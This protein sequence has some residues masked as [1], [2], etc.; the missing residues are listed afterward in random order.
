ME[1]QTSNLSGGFVSSQEWTRLV[2]LCS[3]MTG[4]KDS[5]EDLAQETVLE[6]WLHKHTLRNAGKRDQW[7]SGIARNVC[8]RW[9]RTRG[10]ELA[11]LAI[12]EGYAEQDTSPLE[13]IRSSNGISP[14]RNAYSPRQTL[15]R[16]VTTCR[17]RRTTRHEHECG[18]NA[19]T[20]R[21]TR[22]TQSTHERDEPRNFSL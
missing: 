22:T 2:H 4:N 10:R 1:Q 21:K 6:A 20:T 16:R 15:Y 13:A 18:S 3:A 7:L 19:S 17:G 12:I 14:F 9:L 5:A 11:H 8:L